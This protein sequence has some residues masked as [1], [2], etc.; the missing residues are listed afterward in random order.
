VEIADRI[1]VYSRVIHTL[2]R[3]RQVRLAQRAPLRGAARSPP[4]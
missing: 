2:G 4:R 3:R 1:F